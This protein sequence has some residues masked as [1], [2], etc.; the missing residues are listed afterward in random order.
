M[1]A[2]ALSSFLVAMYTLAFL[3]SNAYTPTARDKGGVSN[4]FQPGNKQLVRDTLTVSLPMPVFP[5]VTITTFP[6]K[7]GMESAVNSDLGA[8]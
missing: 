1:A 6:A 5:P 3:I 4:L 8:K 7:S 2:L